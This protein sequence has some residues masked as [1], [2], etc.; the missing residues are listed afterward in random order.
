MTGAM[1]IDAIDVIMTEIAAIT[2]VETTIVITTK[3]SLP[4][5]GTMMIIE[6][7]KD[8]GLGL[9]HQGEIDVMI[10]KGENVAFVLL[11]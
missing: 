9:D 8:V 7:G 6:T 3:V 11:N 2:E 10:E 4:Q 1:T 5:V